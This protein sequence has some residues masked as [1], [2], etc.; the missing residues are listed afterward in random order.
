MEN[1]AVTGHQN[2]AG[3]SFGALGVVNIWV[4][5][6]MGVPVFMLR[7]DLMVIEQEYF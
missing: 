1:Y 5:I 2:Q 3:S 7:V 6:L 4:L